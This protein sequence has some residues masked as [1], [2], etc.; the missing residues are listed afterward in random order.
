MATYKWLLGVCFLFGVGN[1][2]DVEM[3][4]GKEGEDRVQYVYV[5]ALQ[6]F[7]GKEDVSLEELLYCFWC[8]FCLKPS[9]GSF[10]TFSAIWLC[11]LLTLLL[12][13]FH[14]PIMHYCPP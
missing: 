10:G 9:W 4:K 2:R 14:V 6:K 7:S 11:L 13:E 1:D 5:R 12:L 8:I 3:L